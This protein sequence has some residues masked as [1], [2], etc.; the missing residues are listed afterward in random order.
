M[1]GG[2]P[3]VPPPFNILVPIA[4]PCIITHC[5]LGADGYAAQEHRDAYTNSGGRFSEE[6]PS[7]LHLCGR[8]YCVQPSHIYAGTASENRRDARV[9][10][11]PKWSFAKS[12]FGD[13]EDMHRIAMERAGAVNEDHQLPLPLPQS[14]LSCEHEW[15][16]GKCCGICGIPDRRPD[17][18]WWL[19]VYFLYRYDAN[20]YL[21]NCTM[22]PNKGLK[23]GDAE[24]LEVQP[25]YGG[26]TIRSMEAMLAFEYHPS[27]VVVRHQGVEYRD[28]PAL[29]R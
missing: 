3:V 27:L 20:T 19:C 22:R 16:N 11:N 12:I 29:T 10:K 13:L 21:R 26:Q 7:A 28:M 15:F 9:H 17:G 1:N 4:G 2:S 18:D 25:V 24:A 8:P 6:R 5:R 23:P 14:V